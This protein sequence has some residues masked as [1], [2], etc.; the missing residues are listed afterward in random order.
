VPIYP[1]AI[2]RPLPENFTQSRIAP[3]TVC[4][5]TA[6]SNGN[7]LF[8]F[9]MSSSSEGVESHFYLRKDGT[10][11]Q[12]M[13]TSRRADCQLD[14]NPFCISVESWDGAGVVWDT[15]H[16]EDI[17]AWNTAQVNWLVDLLVWCHK[18]HGIPLRVSRYWNDSG[19]AWHRKYIGPRPS[20]ATKPRACP[21]NRR[22]AQIPGIVALAAKKAAPVPTPPPEDDVTP[23][24][25]QKV[26]AAVL[27]GLQPALDAIKAFDVEA[28]RDTTAK[29]NTFADRELARDAKQ[30]EALTRLETA[31]SAE[32][33]RDNR[34]DEALTRLESAIAALTQQEQS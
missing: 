16:D 4:L 6:V 21:G 22:V 29:L 24:D 20:F 2:F 27:A 9:W 5:H 14:G 33:S 10:A 13:D 18:T 30:D 28:Y 34:Q 23:E 15:D 32:T 3:R 31:A 25:I 1:N 26:S 7:S 19:I 11:E 17:P 12:Y 8:S